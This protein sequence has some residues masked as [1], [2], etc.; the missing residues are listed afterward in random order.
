MAIFL[1]LILIP[2]ILVF[3]KFFFVGPLASADAPY[4]YPEGLK[5]L[6]SS[7]LSWTQRGINFGGPNLFLWIW[8]LMFLYGLLGSFL[9]LGNDLAIRLIFYFPAVLL[10]IIAPIYLTKYLKLSKTVWFFASFVFTLNTYYILLIDGGQVGVALSYGLFPLCLL[11]LKKLV[12]RP[13][14]KN[15]LA[16]TA[17]SFLT[18]L[19]DPRIGIVCFLTLFVW[20]AI[21]AVARRSINKFKN[22]VFV[23]IEIIFLGGLNA[24]WV[25]PLINGSGI[26]LNSGVTGLNLISILNP[27]LLFQPHFPGNEFGKVFP[28]PFYFALVPFLIFGSLL[29]KRNKKA[30]VYAFIFLLFAFLSKGSTFPF[31]QIYD[32]LVKLPFGFAFRDSSKFF[33]PLVLFGGILIG[34]T[35]DSLKPK[36]SKVIIYLFLLFLIYP[37][38]SGKMNFVLS[39]KSYSNDFNKIY[40]HLRDETSFGRT[41]WV[42]ERHPLAYEVKNL[43]VIEG[44]DLINIR[45]IASINSGEDIFNFVN[46]P[47]F[48]EWFRILGIK[49]VIVSG[50][51]RNIT[52]NN[53]D[54]ENWNIILALLNNTQTLEKLD[55]GTSFPI[56]RISN[57]YPRFY[58]VNKLTAVVGS[59][60]TSKG[61]IFT[62]SV[63]LED[64]KVDPRVLEDKEPESLQIFLNGKEKLDLAM[65][66]LQYYFVPASK[67]TSSSWAVYSSDQYLKYKYELLIRGVNYRDFD[68]DQGVAFSTKAGEKINF[69]FRVDK[70]GEYVVALRRMQN[71]TFKWQI[72]DK[73]LLPGYY[74]HEI[75]SRGDVDVLNTIALI[76][77]KDFGEAMN[78]ADFLLRK[79][80]LVK[81]NQVV[82]GKINE[83]T[84]KELG[85]LKYEF[86][87][88]AG[89]NWLVFND[90]Y[91]S[92]W[93]LEEGRSTVKPVP[94]YSVVNGFYIAPNTKSVE[95]S[96][97]GETDLRSGIYITLG[98]TFLFVLFLVSNFLFTKKHD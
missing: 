16:S 11:F 81:E 61:P 54:I 8:P 55:W 26:I 13:T 77:K 9:H 50:N 3:K 56:F 88:F 18:I 43:A 87:N 32:L 76:P 72:E 36:V 47:A 35:A 38:I 23:L 29:I 46:N 40:T 96:Y 80:G 10:S 17:I 30:F 31:G 39:N 24:Y 74:T 89:G 7:P 93:E 4:F 75:E 97:K 48:A 64:G 71:G 37:A 51:P 84:P 86:N 59:D 6:I 52:P 78:H 1:F 42:S 15:F 63:Y 22:L 45:P 44:K 25:L 85:S 79:F 70:E 20:T 5:E 82:E 12:D 28:P 58:S 69:K 73:K 67:N 53:K 41:V 33:A 60:Q 68:Y 91:N 2:V 34:L 65:S 94:V 62:P 49:Y 92:S 27:L 14:L 98:F 90:N 21:E 57:S 83:L 66:Y 19:A 95:L